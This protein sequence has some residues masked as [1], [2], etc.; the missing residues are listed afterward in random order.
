MTIVYA[1]LRFA[2]TF[3]M[4]PDDTFLAI[5][6]LLGRRIAP[7]IDGNMGRKKTQKVLKVD[8][9]VV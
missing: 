2:A 1:V 9:G 6:I 8:R 7:L 4:G 5:R 3:A